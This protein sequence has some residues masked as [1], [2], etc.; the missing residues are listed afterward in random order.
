LLVVVELLV[1]PEEV[2]QRKDGV[3]PLQVPGAGHKVQ[4]VLAAQADSAVPELVVQVVF[5]KA[6]V[7]QIAQVWAEVV[8]TTVVEAAVVIAVLVLA[9]AEAEDLA[10]S[11]LHIFPLLM[12]TKQE[13]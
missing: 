8:A 4:V 6:V 7:V 11:I 5:F 2:L 10:I 13:H 3:G 12:P 1:E 9:Q